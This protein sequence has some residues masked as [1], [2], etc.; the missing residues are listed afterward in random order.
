MPRTDAWVR[1][2]S[3]LIVPGGTVLDL[4]CGRGRHA[5]W[6]R[7]QCLSVVAVDRDEQAL[8][9]LAHESG[10]EVR[11]ADLEDGSWPF[12]PASF[13]GLVVTN[14][15]HRPLFPALVDV[16]RPGGVLIYETFAVGHERFGR[17]SN[18]A[19]LLRRDELLQVFGAH[20]IVAFEQGEVRDPAPAVVQRI[21]AVAGTPATGGTSVVTALP[22][23][24]LG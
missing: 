11:C 19:F 8:S 21:C 16:L 17:P 2:F 5:R 14:Y 24:P 13:D 3:A 18:P 15:L 10:I 23:T 7:S 20:Q 6:L 9:I 1:R 22:Q 4:A 12:A